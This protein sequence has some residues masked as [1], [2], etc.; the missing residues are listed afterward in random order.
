[1][2]Y[3]KLH[4]FLTVVAVQ[5]AALLVDRSTPYWPIEISR[6]AASGPVALL[7]FRTGA[8]ALGAPLAMDGAWSRPVLL[9]WLAMVIIAC[10]DDVTSWLVH[11]M[12]VALL[13]VSACWQTY[14][15]GRRATPILLAAAFVFAIRLV[16]KAS[17]VWWNEVG[18]HARPLS[19]L[20]DATTFH[21]IVSHSAALMFGTRTFKSPWT[22]AA[23]SVGGA[24]Q[25]VVFA[26]LSLLY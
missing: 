22:R 1:M 24:L 13:G 23:F 7:A 14:T 2:F 20:L 4:L 12:G 16:L 26:I 9:L 17:T 3:T 10:V 19:S 18:G 8:L 15:L 21:G 11:M 25:W 5:V 6:M